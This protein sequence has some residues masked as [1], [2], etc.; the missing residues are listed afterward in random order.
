M[1]ENKLYLDENL[2][3]TALAE[4][5]GLPKNTISQVINENFGKNFHDFV[6][7]YRIA[8]AKKLLLSIESKQLQV[9]DIAIEVGYNTKSSFYKAFKKDT[10]LTP[11]QFRKKVKSK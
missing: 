5:L 6:N 1:T 9:T 4:R 8:D 11:H 10:G 7:G 2:S 3:V